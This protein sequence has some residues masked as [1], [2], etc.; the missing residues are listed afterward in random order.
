MTT[1]D[2]EEFWSDLIPLVAARQVVPIVGSDLLTIDD[3][4]R[5]VRFYRRVAERLLER[6]GVD[7]AATN[8]TLRPYHELNDAICALDRLAKRAS[9]DSYLP[10][11]EAIRT[12][13]SA[14]RSEIDEP[15]RQLASID[16]LRMFVTTTSD[17]ALVHALDEVRYGG[18]ASTLQV[19]YAPSGLPKDRTTDLSDL[20]VPDQSAVLYLFGK[21][22][23]SPVFAAHDE[24]VLEFLYGLQAG[25]GQTPKRFFS[26][27]RSSNLLFIGCRFPDWLS[28]FLMRVAAPQRLSEQ[29]GRKDF[30]IDPSHEDPDFAVFLATFARNTRISSM[31]PAAFVAE[32]L[33][34]WQ[35]QHGQ[36][37]SAGNAREV[38]APARPRKP[39]VFISYS[40]TDIAPVRALYDEIRRVAGNDVAWFDKSEMNP[41]DEWRARIMEAVEGCQLFLPIVSLSEEARTEGV[42]IEEWRRALDRARGI[43]GRA[44]IVPVFVDADAESN[45]ARYP[46]ATRLFGAV[47]FGFAPEGRLSPKL[48]S[49]I[50][51]ELRAFRG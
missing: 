14:C 29:R 44:F 43:D 20:D 39:A 31:S 35:A 25:L 5:P 19:E 32:F 34:R 24:D 38:A 46:R 8:T 21:A 42:F 22:A 17:D 33:S 27:I 36:E 40:R 4:G 26:A 16:D 51:R 10:V 9:A 11:H 12:T 1:V 37:A 23:V 50:V 2:P 30:V 3:G 28:R 15:L 18:R 48:E 7:P 47:D 49:M 6:Y 41:G 13:V 45:L